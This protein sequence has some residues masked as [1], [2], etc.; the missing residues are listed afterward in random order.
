MAYA[1]SWPM[2]AYDEGYMHGDSRAYPMYP[3]IPRVREVYVSDLPEWATDGWLQERF[4]ETGDV[5]KA[6][7]IIEHSADGKVTGYVQIE[8]PMDSFLIGITNTFPS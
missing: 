2:Y 6:A 4:A 7:K 8:E 3:P 1:N 5:V